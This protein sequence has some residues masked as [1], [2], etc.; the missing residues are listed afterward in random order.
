MCFKHRP[1]FYFFLRFCMYRDR[2]LLL[3][4]YDADP[5]KPC[6]MDGSKEIQYNTIFKKDNFF[7]PLFRSQIHVHGPTQ[8]TLHMCTAN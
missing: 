1:F 5:E 3:I 8:V 6:V 7:R 2:F 4:M